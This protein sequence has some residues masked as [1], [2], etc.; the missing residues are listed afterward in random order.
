MEQKKK[1]I[2]PYRILFPIGILWAVY[3]VLLWPAHHFQL[4]SYYPGIVGHPESMIAGFIGS[5]ISGFLMTAIPR[6]T[7]AE[8]ATVN[9]NITSFILAILLFVSAVAYQFTLFYLI[10]FTQVLYLFFFSKKRF[11][12]R[13]FNPPPSFIFVGFGIL[14]AVL[15]AIS[16]IFADFNLIGSFLIRLGKVLFYK[17]LVLSMIIGVGS[18]LIPALTGWAELPKFQIET[19][20][21]KFTQTKKII[22]PVEPFWVAQLIGFICA[23]L[24]D[25]FQIL[26]VSGLI[27]SIVFSSIAI[28]IFKIHKLPNVKTPFA[29]SIWIS[30]HSILWSLWLYTFFTKYSVHILHLLFIGGYGLI[31]LLIASRVVNAHGGYNVARTE[32]KKIYYFITALAII[33]ALTRVLAFFVPR[34]YVTHLDYASYTWI[35]CIIVWCIYFFK[36]IFI[37]N[38]K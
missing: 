4:I 27:F 34:L 30:C 35:L 20:R 18:R 3:G 6:F 1:T 16:F 37:E 5:F 2:D 19:I 38:K 33:A 26:T 15:G 13:K 36:K 9:E 25:A 28:R 12:K 14:S 11:L 29:F 17:S 23:V 22:M 8:T 24:L 32:S 21:D 10:L 31:T 7:G